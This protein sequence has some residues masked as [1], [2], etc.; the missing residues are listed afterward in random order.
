M[1]NDFERIAIDLVEKAPKNSKGVGYDSDGLYK[2]DSDQPSWWLY[3][4]VRAI[5]NFLF[6]FMITIAESFE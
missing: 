5:K 3:K 2:T 1:M 6:F 4:I